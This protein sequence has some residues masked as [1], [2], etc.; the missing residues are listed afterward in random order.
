MDDSGRLLPRL[1]LGVSACLA[2]Q[3]VRFDG[4]QRRDDFVTG[5]L[6]RHFELVPVCSEV[7]LGLGVP[8]PTLRLVRGSEVRLVEPKTGRDLSVPMRELADR[9]AIDLRALDLTGFVF[10]KDSPTCGFTRVKVYDGH[11][12]P[13]RDGVGLF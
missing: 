13:A 2:G 4:G 5:V 12:V 7:L 9:T 8:R 1:R 11:G 3:A 10:K 6:A